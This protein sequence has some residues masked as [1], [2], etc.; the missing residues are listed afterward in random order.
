MV[1]QCRNY[2][3]D[4]EIAG[5]IVHARDVSGQE[6]MAGA[7][8]ESEERYRS[9]I[10]AM[11]EGVIVQEP[12]GRIVACNG[13]AE[14]ILGLSADQMEG[15]TSLDPRWRT[16]H[17]DGSP[18]PGET[19]PAMVTLKTGISQSEVI[20]GIHKPDGTLTWISVNTQAIAVP[21][22][23]APQAVVSTFHDITQRRLAEQSVRAHAEEIADL[24][25]RAPCG[26]H[27]LDENA[28]IVRINDTELNWLGRTRE[29]VV[30]KM[31]FP[32]VLA[33]ASRPAFEKHFADFK[34]RGSVRDLEF[35]LVRND[36]TTMTVLVSAT[37]IL[38]EAGRYVS[39]RSTLYDITEVKKQQLEIEFKN[40]V[41][42]TQLEASLD[43]IL[44]VDEQG[45]VISCNRRFV[46]IWSMPKDVLQSSSDER[47]LQWVIEKVADPGEFLKKVRLLYRRKDLK[48]HDKIHLRDG[49]ILD[50]YSAPMAG[51]Q[52]RYY[53]RVW[54]FR[55]VTDSVR[56]EDSLKKV[57][58]ALRVLSAGNTVL[59]RAESE[60]GLLNDICRVIVEKGG[61]RL[62]W[63]GFAEQDEAKTVRP[64]ASFGY[65][66]GYLEN[67]RITWSDDER[68]LG[69][70]GTAIRTGATQVNQDFQ[71]NPRTAPWR[72]NAKRLGFFSSI[73]LPLNDRRGTFGALSIYSSET[74]A[75]DVDEEQLLM[76]LADDLAFGIAAQRT[77]A[78]H[79]RAEETVRRLAYFDP[80]TGLPNRVQL[81]D[82]LQRAVDEVH[83]RR[84]LLAVM[85][86]N[87]DRFSE[88]QAGLGIRQADG[89]LQKVAGRLRDAAGRSRYIARIGGDIFAVLLETDDASGAEAL[90][91]TFLQAMT[92][93][94][95]HGGI[96][97][98]VQ[99][100][101]GTALC[102]D[103]GA[104]ANALLLRSDIAAREARRLGT[105]YA[106]YSGASD[107]ESLQRLG[108][109]A[110]LRQA[111]QQDQ[112]FLHYQPKIDVRAG[113]VSG[114]EALL[115]WQHPERGVIPPDDFIHLAEHS[116]L[117]KPL[118]YWVINAAMHQC[119][120]WR[121]SG[122]A[123]PIAINVSP[124]NL[125][126]PQFMDKLMELRATWGVDLEFLQFE[127]T[128]ST[129]ME[130]PVRS[131]EV[132]ARFKEM[133]VRTFV[134][135]FGTGYSSLGYIA[136]LPVYALKIDRMFV[137]NMMQRSEHL[138]VVNATIQLAHSLGIKVVAEGVETREQAGELSRLGCDEIQGY[139][140]CR[141]L[142]AGEFRDWNR[143]FSAGRFGL[144]DGSG[145]GTEHP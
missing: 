36:G 120:S 11:T 31:R 23:A 127:I 60:S 119:A 117:I 126:D 138:S 94:F 40:A 14:R 69:P 50:R 111:I 143:T 15:R 91:K 12:E 63:V 9:V 42:S 107:Q 140:F 99:V 19:H 96:A 24:Y 103:H 30:G 116:G 139:Y 21:G 39:S 34:K 133:G 105:G 65:S 130:D 67:A 101:I 113:T 45:R 55:D 88:I 29:E 79:R 132:L 82:R 58:R 78:E 53:G 10:A 144:A 95:D 61:Y 81:L 54:Y 38:D 123:I 98:D 75:F 52:G 41:L 121:E 68:G 48:S 26:Y 106:L 3:A 135:D 4:P 20:M 89:L 35:D 13:S 122:G 16:V 141:P 125:R 59:I 110:E 104:E 17:E 85:T 7:L 57:N 136:T 44:V 62:A 92:V 124:I 2:L 72:D 1:A 51:E 70:T 66:D 86:V 134:D 142:P 22:A 25:N 32:D 8:H 83:A 118:T 18:F 112:L 97:V 102:P 5:V 80:L 33:S 145:H 129:L 93:P 76:E 87:I 131:H 46:E 64:V 114:V 6:Q 56:A 115:R 77:R 27:S 109:V 73:S 43:G 28:V 37:A 100:S 108:L 49:R 74:D 84:G 71:S 137:V 47:L 128:E 90:A